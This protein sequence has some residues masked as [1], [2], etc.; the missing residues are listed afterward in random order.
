MLHTDDRAISG[1]QRRAFAFWGSPPL[2]SKTNEAIHGPPQAGTGHFGAGGVSL[3]AGG[4][5]HSSGGQSKLF[6]VPLGMVV[7]QNLALFNSVRSK[8]APVRLA[9]SRLAP[10]RLA[11]LRL[12]LS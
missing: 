4:V 6:R 3:E 10:L 1:P 5:A 9:C 2:T 7:L 12:A 8:S 11:P